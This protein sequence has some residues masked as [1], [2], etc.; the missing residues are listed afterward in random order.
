MDIFEHYL[1]P[2]TDL[3]R[4]HSNPTYAEAMSRYMRNKFVFFGLKHPLLHSLNKPFLK[5]KG[6]PSTELLPQLL[7]ECWQQPEREFQYFALSLAEKSKFY[8]QQAALPVF[9]YM[10]THQSWWDTVDLTASRL[11]GLYFQQFP[12]K[13]PSTTTQ[14]IESDN[15]WLQRAAIIFQLNYKQATDTALLFDLIRRR[16]DSKEFFIQKAIGWA[17]RQYARTDPTQVRTFV[18][19]HTLAPLSRRE[20]LKHIGVKE[21]I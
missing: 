16:A 3:Y 21:E 6:L 17:L 15:F 20:A 7:T 9:E 18:A 4:Q 11:V 14:W 5:E 8:T 13:I 10:I 19:S 1:H 2:L 12:E